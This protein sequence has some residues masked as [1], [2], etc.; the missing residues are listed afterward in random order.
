M[1]N[2]PEQNIEKNN[3]LV[4]SS[5]APPVIIPPNLRDENNF[6]PK[7]DCKLCNSQYRAEAHELWD[8]TQNLMRVFKLLTEDRMEDISYG[9]VRNHI[10]FHYETGSVN[11]LVKEYASE[12]EQWVDLQQDQ[13][14]GLRR[15][16]AQLERQMDIIGAL[17]EGLPLAEQRKNLDTFT[18]LGALLL[19]YRSKVEEIVSAKD[20]VGVVL[21]QLNVI[22]KQ[23]IQGAKSPETKQV[24]GNVFAKLKDSVGHFDY[25]E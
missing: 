22:F 16:M 14:S 9:A 23:E 10:K 4:I 1:E 21:N 11:A 8:R 15:A 5:A 25:E 7:K 19:A 17:T 12:V 3:V 24:I 2:N 20:G 6:F 18:K 13:L